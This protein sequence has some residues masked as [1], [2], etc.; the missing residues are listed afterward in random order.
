MRVQDMMAMR[1][2]SLEWSKTHQ[3]EV[4]NEK[5]RVMGD[6]KEGEKPRWH[7]ATQPVERKPVR[8]QQVTVPPLNKHSSWESLL[9]RSLDGMHT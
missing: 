1:R 9:T 7:P 2:R 8:I 5:F 6:K 3:C 4:F